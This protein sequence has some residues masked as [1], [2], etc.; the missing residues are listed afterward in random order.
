MLPRISDFGL[1][2][3]Q[4]SK[5]RLRAELEPLVG[6]LIA[7]IFKM[8]IQCSALHLAAQLSRRQGR[9]SQVDLLCLRIWKVIEPEMRCCRREALLLEPRFYIVSFSVFNEL[10]S[11]LPEH[12]QRLVVGLLRDLLDFVH[13]ETLGF[14]LNILTHLVVRQGQSKATLDTEG[15]HRLLPLTESGAG[16]VISLSIK[17]GLRLIGL[18]PL[19]SSWPFR[20]LAP[21]PP[22]ELGD[23]LLR[24]DLLM[25][26][27]LRCPLAQ[28]GLRMAVGVPELLIM[29]IACARQLQR[30]RVVV[31]HYDFLGLRHRWVDV[32]FIIIFHW[33]PIFEL[34]IS[35]V[36][37]LSEFWIEGAQLGICWLLYPQHVSVVSL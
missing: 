20:A 5:L 23:W 17:R 18:L 28:L 25:Y 22:L 6:L 9:Y 33:V 30:A 11:L 34:C 32:D 26:R 3:R 14:F 37:A 10:D 24:A 12:L 29:F 35:H 7:C 36:K 1:L 21:L 31:G 2:L 13:H 16:R 27:V 4:V 8:I 15:A 19:T